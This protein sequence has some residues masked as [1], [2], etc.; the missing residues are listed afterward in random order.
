MHT[1]YPDN[2]DAFTAK[3]KSR[4]F[5]SR[6]FRSRVFKNRVFKNRVFKNRVYGSRVYGTR[7][8]DAFTGRVFAGIDEADGVRAL[9]GGGKRKRLSSRVTVDRSFCT[10]SYGKTAD[11]W[12]IE[13]WPST[14]VSGSKA[15]CGPVV[16]CDARLFIPAHFDPKSLSSGFLID[17]VWRK[18]FRV[19]ARAER[20]VRISDA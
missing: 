13:K 3:Y 14:A 2:P 6:V 4:V 17:S 12:N 9:P 7:L 15:R 5:K 16:R 1:F 8:R 20:L 18:R 10:H 19:F 11:S